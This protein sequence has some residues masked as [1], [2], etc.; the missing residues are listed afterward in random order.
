MMPEKAPIFT[1]LAACSL[2]SKEFKIAEAHSRT[3]LS[4]SPRSKR[5]TKI[6]AGALKAQSKS[7]A[8]R[9]VEVSLSMLR[10]E[11]LSSEKK[12]RVE[13]TPAEAEKAIGRALQ[14]RRFKDA[15]AWALQFSSLSALSCR[16]YALGHI[17]YAFSLQQ[18]LLKANPAHSDALAL[19]LVHWLRVGPSQYVQAKPNIELEEQFERA[20]LSPEC[21]TLLH[22]MGQVLTQVGKSPY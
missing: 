21:E 19:E 2:K 13:R 9:L 18:L 17:A 20:A 4:L 12:F 3:A 22:N 16:A 11:N 6:L 5:A 10:A 8:A 14:A 1:E 7:D 15:E